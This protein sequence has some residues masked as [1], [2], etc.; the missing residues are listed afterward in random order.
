LAE[1][2][3]AG[4]IYGNPTDSK[5]SKAQK[6]AKL[7]RALD[8]VLDEKDE[9]DEMIGLVGEQAFNEALNLR[10]CIQKQGFEPDTSDLRIS[11]ESPPN[12]TSN[13]PKSM[14]GSTI[15]PWKSS[16]IPKTFPP[17]PKVLD[18]TL[19]AA[20]F[21]HHGVNGG[22]VTDLSYE[23]LEWIGDSY[24]Y[25]ASTLLVSQTFPSLL[26]GKCSQLREKLV[27]NVTLAGY[28]R[29]YGFEQRAQLPDAFLA[30]SAHPAKDAERTKIMGDIF[31]AYVAA[32][33]LSDPEDG[34]TRATAWLKDLWGMTIQKEILEEEKNGIKIDSPLWRLRG[35]RG[36]DEPSASMQQ[37]LLNPKEKLKQMLGAKGI[38]LEYKDAGPQK[39]DKDSKLTLFTVGVYLSG[40]GEKDKLLGTGTAT[41]KKDAGMK[42]AAKA[43]ENKKAMKLYT[44]KK[45]VFDAQLE[46]E[47]QTLEKQQQAGM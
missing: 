39:K 41:G 29:Q 24:I 6:V 12:R 7:M 14:S 2:G 37:L 27:K 3:I 11:R 36:L 1:R 23:R 43:L 21:I 10:A 25:V 46:L 19:E 28:A 17:L 5:A 35:S 42:A 13:L 33:V 32:V 20:A 16:E 15:S 40:W 18:P 47:R 38:K 26:P 44:E 30:T 31:E 9:K 4:P 22:R 8:D 45:K 34:L